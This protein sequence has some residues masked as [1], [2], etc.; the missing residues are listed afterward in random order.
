METVLLVILPV[1]GVIALGYGAARFGFM[2]AA[3]TD[4]FFSFVF[5]MAL[6]ALLVGA[7]AGLDLPDEIPWAL[8]ATYFI[9]MI[10]LWVLGFYIARATG[11]PKKD[12]LVV[13]LAGAQGN[14]DFLGL[15]IL[16]TLFGTQAA[17]PLFLILLLHLPVF[18]PFAT[19]YLEHRSAHE[20]AAQREAI[21]NSL[22]GM[23]RNPV[24]LA[25]V[26]G[27]LIALSGVALPAVLE[28]GLGL[29]GQATIP[30]ALFAL[31]ATLH[32]YEIRRSLGLAFSA[33]AIKLAAF[34]LFVWFLGAHVFGL[35]ALWLQVAVILAAM[36]TGLFGAVLAIRYEAAP[37]AS[38]SAVVLSTLLSL[39]SLF[40]VLVLLG[41]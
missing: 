35:E 2:S 4:A 37:G 20:G 33:S 10:S 28:R 23:A 22:L 17:A 19:I 6:P 41:V 18:A 11:R 26:I 5:S 36:P 25:L 38:S 7:F 1:F 29:L 3:A 12:S 31:G 15:P 9:P 30:C 21:R 13:G 40:V 24:I 27:L 8:W 34:P 14:T 32:R 16:L 39:P